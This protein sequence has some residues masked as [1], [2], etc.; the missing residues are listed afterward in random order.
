MS[1]KYSQGE[2]RLLISRS[3]LLHNARVLRR[4]VG[5]EV[6]I[7]AILKADGYGHGA[8]I[9]ADTLCNFTRDAS[10]LR[11]AVDAI[12]VATI[13]EAL[14]LPDVPVPVIVFRPVENLF[15]GRQRSKIEQA[16]RDGLVLTVCSQSAAEDLA[17]IAMACGR[18]AA[19]QIIVDTGMT[20]SGVNHSEFSE[21]LEKIATRPSLRLTG[22]CTHF[23]NADDPGD[24]CTIEQIDRF[25]AV[26]NTPAIGPKVTRHAANSAAIFFHATSHF[27]MVRPGLALYGIDPIGKPSLDRPLRPAMRW[28]AP[29]IGIRDVA[30]G[31]SV[32]YAHTWQA[33]ADTRI[34][35]VPVGYADGYLR[36]FSNQATVMVGG[37]AAPVVGRVSMDLITIDL[38]RHPQAAIGD[39]VTLL[40]N[41]PLSPASVYRLA[42]LAQTIPY[43]IFCRI[44][45]RVQRVAMEPE[46]A[47]IE[48]IE[49]DREPAF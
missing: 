23:A 6:R 42:E 1:V 2:P 33:P 48:P 3:A 34:G 43:E 29:L 20:R 30:R 19:I 46:E 41:D 7:C 38:G 28:T 14:S 16:I 17:R 25:A 36:C 47:E 5:A 11:P 39:E 44:G 26:T 45:P 21:L 8:E 35:L 27:D 22:V 32:G 10:S 49:Q 15:V 13:D 12:A 37:R 24:A 9:V 4:A 31:T 18:R 40:D